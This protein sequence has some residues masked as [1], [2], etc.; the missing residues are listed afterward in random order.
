MIM[1]FFGIQHSVDEFQSTHP[2][3]D[4]MSIL[5]TE[6]NPGVGHTRCRKSDKIGIMSA[7]HVS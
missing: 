6:D 7:Q 5:L 4:T 2:I 3:A 1:H